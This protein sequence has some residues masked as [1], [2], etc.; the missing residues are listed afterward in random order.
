[1]RLERAF[2]RFD[3]GDGLRLCVFFFSA[4]ECLGLILMAGCFLCCVVSGG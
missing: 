4:V 3:D 2:L 1:M